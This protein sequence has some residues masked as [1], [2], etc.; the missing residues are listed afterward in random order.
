MEF[1]RI[2]KLL[3][4]LDVVGFW[5]KISSKI[6]GI[7]KI[8]KVWDMAALRCKIAS[9]NSGIFKNFENIEGVRWSSILAQNCVEKKFQN[10]ENIQGVRRSGVSAKIAFS[11]WNATISHTF[12]PIFKILQ[13]SNFLCNFTPKCLRISRSFKIAS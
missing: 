13:N 4:A 12:I 2:L 1:S 6:S 5:R 8:S 3:K 9:K 11:L 10:F 7:Y